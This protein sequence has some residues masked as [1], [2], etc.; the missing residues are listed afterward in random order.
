[1]LGFRG[2]AA[3]GASPPGRGGAALR[4]PKSRAGDVGRARPGGR[5]AGCWGGSYLW[6]RRG[7]HHSP[8]LFGGSRFPSSVSRVRRR[9]Q[10]PRPPGGRR[11]PRGWAQSP[12]GPRERRPRIPRPVRETPPGLGRH[13]PRRTPPREHALEAKPRSLLLPGD[14]YLRRSPS[15]SCQDFPTATANCLCVP[16]P[17][18]PARPRPR[19]RGPAPRGSPAAAEQARAHLPPTPPAAKPRTAPPGPASARDAAGAGCLRLRGHAYFPPSEWPRLPIPSS[20]YGR[21]ETSV[22]D[23]RLLH[24]NVVRLERQTLGL[25]P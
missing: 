13:I 8:F 2:R 23:S 10:R 19:S 11:V 1:L 14:R 21:A 12:Q 25:R 17:L 15:P 24:K 3:G 9:K 20:L 5:A 6:L 4:E 16:S 22:L 7:G 18:R